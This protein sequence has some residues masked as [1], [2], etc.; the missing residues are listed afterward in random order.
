MKA[1]M[2]D[3]E[4]ERKETGRKVENEAEKKEGKE[5]DRIAENEAEMKAEMETEKKK[6][7]ETDR[8]TWEE[9][10]KKAEKEAQE[11]VEKEAEKEAEN[12]AENESK[13]EAKKGFWKREKQEARDLDEPFGL[14]R[15]F[16]SFAVTL[17]FVTCLVLAALMS[18]RAERL[19]FDRVVNDTAIIMENMTWQMFNNFLKPTYLFRGEAKLSDSDIYKF[20][21]AVIQTTTHGFQI[22]SVTIYDDRVGMMVYSSRSPDP[23]V[24]VERSDSG[25]VKLSG[26][27]AVPMQSW[28]EA[29]RLSRA[30]PM[31]APGDEEGRLARLRARTVVVREQG[32]YRLMGFLPVGP[33]VIRCFQAMEDYDTGEPSG[34]LELVRDVTNEYSRIAEMQIMALIVA[35]VS[36]L[37]LFF[38]LWAVVARGE[39]IIKRQNEERAALAMRLHQAERLANL[40]QMVAT[41]SHEIRNPLGIIRSTADFLATSLDKGSSRLGKLAGA[42]VDESERLWRILTDFLDFARPLDPVFQPAVVEDIL[43]E[44]KVLLEIDMNKAGVELITEFRAD[45]GPLMV[46]PPLLHRAFMNLLVNAIQAMPDG[47]LLTVGT[48]LEEGEDSPGRLLVTITDTGPG[49][50]KKA[51]DNLFMPFMTTKAKGT[52]LGLV[53]VRR[54]VESHGGELSFVNLDDGPDNHGLKVTISLPLEPEPVPA[55]DGVVVVSAEFGG[56]GEDSKETGEVAEIKEPGESGEPNE[57]GASGGPGEPEWLERSMEAGKAEKP[58]EPEWPEASMEVGKAGKIGEIGKTGEPGSPKAIG[59]AQDGSGE[60]EPEESLAAL[61]RGAETAAP[62]KKPGKPGVPPPTGA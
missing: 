58:G 26:L 35:G 36:S 37:M 19:I 11:E 2:K 46:D 61:K 48:R 32:D 12:E 14:V 52:G 8:K 44:I 38:L 47:G 10:A 13:K 7:K 51:V 59:E 30:L 57:S 62:G 18:R 31:S 17:I 24:N 41:V 39:S 33:F 9:A 5:V 49:L 4:K 6:G 27:R 16:S 42:I 54:V 15:Y 53:M 20:L 28:L 40:G 21:D 45:P 60:I 29:L 23:V 50:S 3:E 55:G 34:V 22:P 43:D 56:E 25:Q 1:E